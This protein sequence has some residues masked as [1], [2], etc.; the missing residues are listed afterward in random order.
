MKEKNGLSGLFS[1]KTFVMILSVILAIV[2]WAVV[3]FAISPDTEQIISGVTV[4]LGQDNSS[5]QSIGLDITDRSDI[6]VDVKVYGPRSVVGALTPEDINIVPNYSRVDQAGTFTLSLSPANTN[7]L[8]GYDIISVEP[9]TITLSFDV[10]KSQRFTVEAEGPGVTAA[11]GYVIEKI[12]VTPGDVRITGPENDMAKIT[13]VAARYDVSGVL[14]E[15]VIANDCP[16]ILY[17]AEG[18]ELPQTTFTIDYPTVDIRIPVYKLGVLPLTIEFTN[19]PDGF[20]VSS[21]DYVLSIDELEVAGP[22]NTIDNLSEFVVGRVDL[23]TF[24]IGD[25]YTFDVELPSALINKGPETVTVTFPKENISSKKITVSNIEVINVPANYEVSVVTSRINDVTVI[26]L[27][28]DVAS[29]LP[30]SVVAI[31]DFSELTIES[32]RYS[33]P[34]RFEITSNNTTW[35]AGSYTVYIDVVPI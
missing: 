20:D 12:S 5:F 19:V 30:G 9:G 22:E 18:N 10:S 7:P 4:N 24:K 13:R 27:A 21:L 28:E 3:V 1:N 17:D 35:V 6:K 26:G 11:D 2:L 32:G 16:L 23:T 34:V 14:T 15:T 29:L 8:D 25:T 33:V 31:V